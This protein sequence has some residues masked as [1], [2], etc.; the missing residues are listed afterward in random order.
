MRRVMN[1]VTKPL[2][3][4]SLSWHVCLSLSVASA[5]RPRMI[6]FSKFLR[7]SARVPRKLGLAKLRR[8]KY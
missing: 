5:S 4:W 7:K 2:I 1:L 8:E 3:S 6:A